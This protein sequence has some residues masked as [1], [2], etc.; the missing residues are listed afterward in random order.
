MVRVFLAFAVL[1]TAPAAALRLAAR[2]PVARS[3]R[4]CV[5]CAES[6][7]IPT[8]AERDA[9][10][11]EAAQKKEDERKAAQA[12]V[13]AKYDEAGQAL[14]TAA[15]SAR[16]HRR[17]RG[18]AQATSYGPPESLPEKTLKRQEAEIAQLLWAEVQTVY[19]PLGGLSCEELSTRY[20]ALSEEERALDE[21][22][23]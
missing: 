6:D 23:R 20:L 15:Q 3:V 5:L 13:A 18:A 16:F 9:A 19:P 10:L 11:R 12:R 22:T 7:R 21:T 2:A 17:M 1:A 8:L 14:V 4:T